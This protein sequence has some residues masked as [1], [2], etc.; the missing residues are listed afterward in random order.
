MVKDTVQISL[1]SLVENEKAFANSLTN[2]STVENNLG[3]IDGKIIGTGRSDYTQSS[4][5]YNLFVH[6]NEFVLID[7]PGIEGDERKYTEIIKASLAKAHV[8]FYVNGSG[9]KVEKK[10]LEKI[11][12]Y[13]HD[14]TSVYAIFNVHCKAKKRRVKGIDKTYQEELWEAYKNQKEIVRQT[15][16]EL[17]PFLG[18]NF[19]GSVCLNGLLSFCAT[20]VD[21]CGSSTIARDE[22]KNLRETQSKFLKEYSDDWDT[23]QKD[24]CICDIQDIIAEKVDRFDDYILEENLK[25]LRTRLADVISDITQLRETEKA[26]IKTFLREYDTFE[27]N[28]E[29]ARDDL[30]QTINRIG[31]NEV[32]TAFFAVQEELFD[33]VEKRRGK[34][35]SSA[36]EEIFKRH[37]NQITGDIQKGVNS[38]IQ[39][40]VAEYR[41]AI[42]EAEKRLYKDL[43]RSQKAF[44][45]AM[46]DREMHFGGSIGSVFSIKDFGRGAFKIANYTL[47]GFQVGTI[48]PVI[49]NIVG[50]VIGFFVGIGMAI[51]GFFASE[52]KRIN[53]AKGKIKQAID[54]QIDEITEEV[55]REIKKLKL[56]TE[57]NKKHS[58]IKKA[59][60]NQRKSLR[61]IDLMLDTVAKALK[62]RQSKI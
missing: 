16:G 1:S 41:E 28:C 26:K 11:K 57:I 8:I 5:E 4:T 59:I 43:Q 30:I 53:K 23:M 3:C 6:D 56:E 44:Q 38:K 42:Q 39:S 62:N 12:K 13:M 58:E 29:S 14:G 18:E 7:I 47:S 45:I 50:A 32:T 21:S 10:S 61:D 27:K 37:Q 60:E 2:I 51:G 46:K 25:K 20:A 17:K 52:A 22:D 33:D 34:I 55:K 35:N 54:D 31:R 19:K 24:S 36:V 48:V 15:E 49:G 40:A 9:K